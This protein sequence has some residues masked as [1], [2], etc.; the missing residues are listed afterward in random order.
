[1]STAVDRVR[2]TKSTDAADCPT[3][4]SNATGIDCISDAVTA[5][6]P[7]RGAAESD[8]R[9]VSRSV[10]APG[11]LEFNAARTAMRTTIAAVRGFEAMGD[12]N[13][14]LPRFVRASTA[15]SDRGRSIGRGLGHGDAK[16][17]GRSPPVRVLISASLG[18][19]FDESARK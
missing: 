1:M 8:S 6:E 7:L 3:F 19:L 9:P 17:R 2:A 12:D 13:L 11:A 10:D 16:W 15:V 18:A 5:L 14:T 4:G